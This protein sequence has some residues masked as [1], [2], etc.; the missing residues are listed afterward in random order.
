MLTEL[1]Q[2]QYD[3]EHQRRSE[4]T[5]GTAA[6]IAATTVLSGALSVALLD[7]P[8]SESLASVL[9]LFLAAST[10][11][12]LGFAILYI[13]RSTWNYIYKRLAPAPALAA[14]LAELTDWH[15]QQGADAQTAKAA[16]EADLRDYITEKLS[17]AADWNG[18]NNDRKGN[19]LHMST[20]AIAIALAL[21]VPT[22]LLY[23]Y[24]KATSPDKVHRVQLTASPSS[25]QEKTMA[26]GNNS[27]TPTAA[28]APTPSAP[29]AAPS[30]SPSKPVGPPN[31]QFRT[32]TEIPSPQAESGSGKKPG[33]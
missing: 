13:F 14:H 28:P 26:T 25:S 24:T 5:A 11:I 8:Y 9:F 16:A 7:F 33:Q 1:F 22:A 21:F 32:N 6:P 10:L 20:T 23:A 2:K 27:G 12:A 19:F 31:S 3:F 17:E 29:A 15:L 18:Q 4:V 30:S